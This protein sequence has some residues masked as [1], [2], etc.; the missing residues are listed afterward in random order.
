M[1]YLAAPGE[2]NGRSVIGCPEP[3][4]VAPVGILRF[5]LGV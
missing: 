2:L 3:R 4:V 1:L 5:P